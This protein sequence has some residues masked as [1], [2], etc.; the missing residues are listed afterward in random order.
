M[1]DLDKDFNELRVQFSPLDLGA[2]E[3]SRELFIN[4][5]AEECEQLLA[6]VVNIATRSKLRSIYKG[7]IAQG[8]L[9]LVNVC[10]TWC[11]DALV[12]LSVNL[13]AA[14]AHTKQNGNRL[15]CVLT[16]MCSGE[17]RERVAAVFC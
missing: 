11:V 6:N 5:T 16:T 3:L 9:L 7:G 4:L 1:E 8:K 12:S 15:V 17:H 14:A 10:S 2:Q 13:S